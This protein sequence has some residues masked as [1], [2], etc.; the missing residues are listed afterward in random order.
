MPAPHTQTLTPSAATPGM[1]AAVL[2]MDEGGPLR[3]LYGLAFGN[4]AAAK[5][6][7][8]LQLVG[9]VIPLAVALGLLG[10]RLPAADDTGPRRKWT[11]LVCVLFVIPWLLHAN[12]VDNVA[13]SVAW[14]ERLGVTFYGPMPE[15]PHRQPRMHN[16]LPNS[17]AYIYFLAKEARRVGVDIRV[18]SR[19]EKLVVENGRVVG[20]ELA[21]GATLQIGDGGRPFLI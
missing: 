21:S 9:D 19:V 15:P 11:E 4:N 14:L 7:L 18:K 6:A 3:A 17:R 5:Y 12:L 2:A 8:G 16:I 13:E 10:T 1:G 20:V